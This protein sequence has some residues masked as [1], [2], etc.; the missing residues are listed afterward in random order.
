M[1]VEEIE[2]SSENRSV[3]EHYLA[4]F[5]WV[6]GHRSQCKICRGLCHWEPFQA[7]AGIWED[8]AQN[9]CK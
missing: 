9:G 7:M 2:G 3:A 1:Y 8:V 6:H 5:G 4:L